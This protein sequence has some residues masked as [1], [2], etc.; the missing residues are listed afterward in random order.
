MQQ[1]VASGFDVAAQARQIDAHQPT[2]PFASLSGDKHMLDVAGIHHG[3][4]R[5]GNVVHGEHVDAIGGEQNDVGFLAR[6]ERSDFMI[7]VG[8]PGTLD[9]GEFNGVAAGKQAGNTLHWR[10]TNMPR[11][12]NASRG[13]MR[14][15][16]TS[17]KKFTSRY[18]SFENFDARC[19]LRT[20]IYRFAHNVGASHVIRKK[21]NAPVFLTLEDLEAQKGPQDVEESVGRQEALARLLA[22]IQ[23]LEFVDRQLMVAYLEGLDAE[24]MGQ[25]TGLSAANVWT[26]IHRIKTVLIRQFH[27]GS[28]DAT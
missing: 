23:R 27:S 2:L 21:R 26:R 25:I 6:R 14:R 5:T 1:P 7:Q 10:Q 24:S 28:T 13:P 18:G 16:P 11:S 12:W 9:G 3:H 17:C 8:H 20:W 15:T 22:L 19:S 4:H